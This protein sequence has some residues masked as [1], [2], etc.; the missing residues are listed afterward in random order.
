MQSDQPG[1][2]TAVSDSVSVAGLPDAAV[3]GGTYSLQLMGGPSIR[4][5]TMEETFG[6][7]VSAEAEDRIRGF[8]S[9]VIEYADYGITIPDVPL[10]ASVDDQLI[11][12]LDFVAIK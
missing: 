1:N 10:V 7:E 12:E 11:L 9:T 6:G 8:F 3:V 5:A 2:E 4:G